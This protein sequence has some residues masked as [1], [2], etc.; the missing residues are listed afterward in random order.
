MSLQINL[1]KLTNENIEKFHQDL[2]LKLESKFGPPKYFTAYELDYNDILTLPYAYAVNFG[3]K[4]PPREKFT[5][6]SIQFTSEL[7]PEQKEVKK[8]AITVLNKTG[9]IIISSYPGWGK[10]LG[11]NTPVIM[12][13]GTIK[14]VQ[15]IQVG[16]KLMGD[17]S[18]VRNVLSICRGQENMYKIIQKDGDSFTCNESHILSLYV[19]DHKKII[20][21]CIKQCYNFEYFDFVNKK[22]ITAIFHTFS[23]VLEAQKL[24]PEQKIINISVKEYLQLDQYTQKKLKTYKTSIDLPEIVTEKPPYIIGQQIINNELDTIPNIY[25]YNSKQKRKELID[26]ILSNS[27]FQFSSNKVY[28]VEINNQELLQD[29]IYVVRSVG[30]NCF[31]EKIN[32]KYILSVYKGYTY[33]DFLIEPIEDKNYYGFTIDGNHLFLLGDFTVTHNTITAINIASTINMKTL[34]IVNKLVLMEQW[35]D[36]I[37]KFCPNATIQ[38]LTT[39]S[40]LEDVDF[41]IVNA[42]NVEKMGNVFGNIG[43]LIIDELHLIMAQTLSKSLN[44]IHC[45]YLIGLSATPYREDGLDCLIDLYCGA[46]KIIRKLYRKHLVY[47]ID[48]GFKPIV[49]LAKNGKVNWSSILDQQANEL[50]RNEIAVKIIK[51]FRE[52]TFMILVK[53]ISQGKYLVDRLN[54]EGESVGSLLGS[55]QEFDRNVRILIGTTSKIGVGFD[56]NKANSIILITDLESYFIQF[57]GRIFRTKDGIPLVFDLVDNNNILKSHFNTRKSVYIEHGGIVKNYDIR[58]LDNE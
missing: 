56:W 54:E 49:E 19:P 25:K 17:D 34:I 33:S 21:D 40:E 41:Y 9:S 7:R 5:S 46:H 22:Y 12:H 37:S 57:L 44:Y 8:E 58:E 6:T 26:G 43:C 28:D 18:T 4:R 13:D 42:I 20:Y 51:K 27:Y 32:K 53:R 48:T 11:Y 23:G 24:L 31:Y 39:K 55:E 1:N 47:K 35:A 36:S 30:Y 50:E 14:M 15:D 3:I 38:K 52:N 45:R 29:I 2:N 10:C 16:D